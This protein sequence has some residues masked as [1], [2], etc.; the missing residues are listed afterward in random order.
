[1]QQHRKLNLDVSEAIVACSIRG[2]DSKK[3][4]SLLAWRS[5]KLR[6]LLLLRHAR[7]GDL[8]RPSHLLPVSWPNVNDV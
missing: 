8:P 4:S 7:T 6:S 2:F 3:S 1:M 5:L